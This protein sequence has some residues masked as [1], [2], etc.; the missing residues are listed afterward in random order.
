MAPAIPTNVKR[1]AAGHPT[2]GGKDAIIAQAYNQKTATKAAITTSDPVEP[3]ND[4]DGQNNNE[5]GQKN[6]KG[7][8]NDD[9]DSESDDDEP[10]IIENPAAA[11]RDAQS[12]GE[13][14]GSDNNDDED[15][16]QAGSGEKK[17]LSDED[18]VL[19]EGIFDDDN[20][21][22]YLQ[23]EV[24]IEGTYYRNHVVKELRSEYCTVVTKGT[25][26]TFEL[27]TKTGPKKAPKLSIEDSERKTLEAK[28]KTLEASVRGLLWGN[29]MP[30]DSIYE[31]L[32]LLMASLQVENNNMWYIVPAEYTL[33]PDEAGPPALPKDSEEEGLF[34]NANYTVHLVQ[35][36]KAKVYNKEREDRHI[37]VLIRQKK[38]GST[39]FLDSSGATEAS[40][41]KHKENAVKALRKWMDGEL[42][43]QNLK[44]KDGKHVLHVGVDD[45][46]KQ[47][48]NE[49]FSC[50]LHAILNAMVFLR[51]G[52]LGWHHITRWKGDVNAAD[53]KDKAKG[54]TYVAFNELIKCFFALLRVKEEKT[55]SGS[56]EFGNWPNG[57]NNDYHMVHAK[58]RRERGW[59][60][61]TLGKAG[62]GGKNDEIDDD[63]S[64][65]PKPAKTKSSKQARAP[66]T[67]AASG[68][69][70]PTKKARKTTAATSSSPR[71]RKAQSAP[72]E[73]DAA[74]NN[75]PTTAT[76]PRPSK[77]QKTPP[78]ASTDVPD[79]NAADDI[80]DA[81]DWETHEEEAHGNMK[82]LLEI[83]GRD[84]AAVQK[85]L[86]KVD[87]LTKNLQDSRTDCEEI[88]RQNDAERKALEKQFNQFLAVAA[89]QRKRKR[90]AANSEPEPEQDG[91]AATTAA[92]A[93][94]P[95]SPATEKR[96]M[97]S[98]RKSSAQR[99]A[100][101]RNGNLPTPASQS[102]TSVNGEEDEEAQAPPSKRRKSDSA[103][104]GLE[105][106][107]SSGAGDTPS[108]SSEQEE[109]PS[110]DQEANQGA[111]LSEE[112]SEGESE[113]ESDIDQDDAR[114]APTEE[115]EADAAVAVSKE[116]IISEED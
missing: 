96:P 81:M 25:L 114:D 71:K 42:P 93:D 98:P 27:P 8:Q 105:S 41:K 9:E 111:A 116:S 47:P 85:H 26:N 78:P 43:K 83:N 79:H 73:D 18:L 33:V 44:A 92:E 23:D 28:R 45:I 1:N 51:L 89:R 29:W 56:L 64:E 90:A 65:A 14:E 17:E 109:S 101:D 77:R 30:V 74:D 15:V 50:S 75:Q 12:D 63:A 32:V 108:E 40:R 61:G 16:D 7:G 20:Q 39:W 106:P 24:F 95:L 54:N 52:V 49:G 48:K 34:D 55:P 103:P 4:K 99:K 22:T 69:P 57:L 3:E 91:E 10:F 88:L 86:R 70:S 72:A 59:L 2:T 67:A 19:W 37:A 110:A 84:R 94:A 36:G 13:N 46:P 68:L 62:A 31:L 76:S 112:E 102:A 107:S 115:N 5:D 58:K 11:Q 38:T 82:K 97:A 53:Q 104:E 6:D 113:A 80:S 66:V 87:T 60:D 100:D 21:E 35:F